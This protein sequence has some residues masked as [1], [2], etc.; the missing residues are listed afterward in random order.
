MDHLDSYKNLM[1]FQGYSDEVI[2]K[3]FSA[4][5]KEL[6]RVRKKNGSHFFIVHQKDGESLKGYVKWLNQA[7][8]EVEGASDKVVVM[9]MIGVDLKELA[10]AKHRRQGREVHKRKEHESR[11]AAYRDKVKNRDRDVRRKTNDQRPRTPP[12][13]P[14]LVLPPLN[15][16]IAQVLIE[17]KHEEF[18]KWSKKIKTDPCKRNKNKYC[19]FYRDHGHNTEDCFQLK[20]QI[21]DLIKRGYLSKYVSD[22]PCLDSPDRRYGD[23]RPTTMRYSSDSLWFWIR[24]MLKLVPKEICQRS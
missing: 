17:I 24:G 13:L 15:T 20:E 4:T 2:C 11:R 6:A 18:I 10:E 14:N 22:R 5:L 16:P 8:L 7:V 19:E 1:K 21:A 9:A 23:N 12:H 3:A